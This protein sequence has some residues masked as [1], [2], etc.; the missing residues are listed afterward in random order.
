MKEHFGYGIDFSLKNK[1]DNLIKT[2]RRES[3]KGDYSLTKEVEV[4]TLVAVISQLKL[5]GTK[6]IKYLDTLYN[7][8]LMAMNDEK[9]FNKNNEENDK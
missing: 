8:L 1:I 6:Q 2:H 7:E 9:I 5:C 4:K 3:N